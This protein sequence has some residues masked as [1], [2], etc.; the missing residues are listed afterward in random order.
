MN[1]EIKIIECP[2]DAMQGIHEF[3]PTKNKIDLI[4][5]IIKCGFDTIDCGSFVSSKHIPQLAD[6]PEMLRALENEDLGDTKLLTIVANERG[7]VRAAAFPQVSYLGYPFSVSEMF[8][9][10]NTNA[11]RQDAF[12]RLK[13]IKDIADAS[14]KK[15]VAY[16]SM[17]FGNPYEEEYRRDEVMEWADKIASLGIQTISLADTVGQA[18]SQDIN[19][20]FSKLVSRHPS[21]EFGAHFHSEPAHWQTK[22]EEAYNAGCLRFDGAFYGVG[23]CPMAGNDLVGN[24][25]TEHLIQFFSEKEPINLDLKEVQKSMSL[26]RS[27]YT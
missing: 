2:R 8:Q 27:I 4:K 9:R 19:Y 1:K 13:S 22:I 15:V 26:A 10:K 7:A 20:L 25:A 16:I 17:A 3:I 21:V 14:S 23:G 12:F 24:I 11:S 6:T 18:Q 5:S